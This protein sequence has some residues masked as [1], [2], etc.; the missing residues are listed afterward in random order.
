MGVTILLQFVFYFPPSFRQLHGNTRTKLQEFHRID[1]VGG[2]LLIAGLALFLLGVS[3]GLSSYL[4]PPEF[5]T[6]NRR[7]TTFLV[8][9]ANSWSPD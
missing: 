2:F 1:F 8:V 9:S 3:W 6:S 5:L 4:L 7:T